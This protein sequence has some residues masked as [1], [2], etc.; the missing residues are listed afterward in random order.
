MNKPVNRIFQ[1]SCGVLLSESRTVCQKKK[2]KKKRT[3][4]DGAASSLL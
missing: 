1:S 3:E 4:K 2:K